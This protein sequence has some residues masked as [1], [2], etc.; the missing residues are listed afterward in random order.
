MRNKIA[1]AADLKRLP[2]PLPPFATEIPMWN[3][4][5]SFN[6][7]DARID[8]GIDLFNRQEFFPC[9][10]VFEDLWSEIVGPDRIFFQGL[11]H[12]AVCLYHFEGDN[13]TGARKMYSS[14]RSYI[15]EFEPVFV[16]IEAARLALD[17]EFCFQE[18]LAVHSGYPTGLKLP[19]DRVPQIHRTWPPPR[20]G[21]KP[22][23]PQD[24]VAEH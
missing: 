22:P 17:M 9:H 10:D 12:A 13:L 23:P 18:L 19:V 21:P 11:I 6:P 5:L 1:K 24:E 7:D 4:P 16:G 15:S 2:V 14:F 8:A 3:Q 20:S